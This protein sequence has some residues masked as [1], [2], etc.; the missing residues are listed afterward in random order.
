MNHTTSHRQSRIQI[1]KNS[2]ARHPAALVSVSANM[3]A[4]E[5][6]TTGEFGH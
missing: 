4:N 3:L 5:E 2:N 6:L 1:G